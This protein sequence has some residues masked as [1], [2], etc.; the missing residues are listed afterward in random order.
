MQIILP[1]IRGIVLT[2]GVCMAMRGLRV[3]SRFCKFYKNTLLVYNSDLPH[4][5]SLI[6]CV[7]ALNVIFCFS[8]RQMKA[9]WG[10]GEESIRRFSPAGPQKCFYSIL[11]PLS[12]APLSTE[13]NNG[14]F[15]LSFLSHSNPVCQHKKSPSTLTHTPGQE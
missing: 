13:A 6:L 9:S 14:I 11:R 5:L 3:G 2:E 15:V 8:S 10:E 7:C 12:S 1:A 4:H